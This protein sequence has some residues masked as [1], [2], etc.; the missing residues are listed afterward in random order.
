MFVGFDPNNPTPTPQYFIP[1][2]YFIASISPNNTINTIATT[3]DTTLPNN[4]VVGQLMRFYI[5]QGYGMT[6]LDGQS[7]YVT[8]INSNTEFVV[9]V[10]T[11]QYNAFVIPGSPF[12]MQKA[13]VSAIGDNNISAPLNAD[14]LVL[15]IL[16]IPGAFQNIS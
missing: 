8:A 9:N 16:T 13:Q 4:V 5:P 2:N 15:N 10:D 3:V 7:G 14:G 1:Q 12:N 11:S 6:Q